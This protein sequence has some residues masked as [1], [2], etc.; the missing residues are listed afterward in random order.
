[1]SAQ[2]RWDK[3]GEASVV[4]CSA[5]AVVLRSSVPSPPGSRIEGVLTGEPPARVK[6]KVHSSKKQPEGDYLLEGRT[7]DA[8][9]EVR[10]RLERG[11]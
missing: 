5:G 2:V 6:V 4:S 1:M 11:E 10:E 9:R 3:G 7:V 8:T